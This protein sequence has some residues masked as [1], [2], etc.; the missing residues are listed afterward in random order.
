MYEDKKMILPLTTKMP[1]KRASLPRIVFTFSLGLSFGFTLS[2]L[3]LSPYSSRSG[4]SLGPFSKVA[5]VQQETSYVSPEFLFKSVQA[6]FEMDLDLNSTFVHELLRSA[7]EV[8]ARKLAQQVRILC[9]VITVPKNHKDRAEHVR[10]TW[11]RHCNNI[12]FISTKYDA[13]LP[14]TNVKIA[15]GKN[16]EWAK[17]EGA[18]N[19]L[20]ETRLKDFDWVVKTD[21]ESFIVVEN[22]RTMLTSYSPDDPIY[23][24]LS[25][26]VNDNT[27]GSNTASYVLSRESVIRLVIEGYN[28]SK[29]AD[30]SGKDIKTQLGS[31]FKALKL[32]QESTRDELNRR[33]CLPFHQAEDLKDIQNLEGDE[34]WKNDYVYWPMNAGLN[35]CSSEPISFHPTQVSALYMLEYMIYHVRPNSVMRHTNIKLPEE[36]I[37][38]SASTPAAKSS[39]TQS[40][41]KPTSE[42]TP[43]PTSSSPPSSTTTTTIKASSPPSSA[44]PAGSSPAPT[45]PKS[46]QGTATSATSTAAN[47][48]MT[49]SSAS[50]VA[51]VTSAT[52]SV[53]ATAKSK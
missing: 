12:H 44:G 27:T 6:K 30:C 11:G 29:H 38:D 23:F 14:T 13:A 28:G 2:T 20:H 33:R 49:G 8:A 21:H 40:T 25:Y 26:G 39:S 3:I 37:K 45:T 48:S 41:V 42:T 17:M 53:A 22:L 7:E 4:P 18:F 50:S 5:F 10:E 52:S 34:W 36:K 16:L 15:E 31:C 47:T 24:E 1:S 51:N 43:K 35:C 9:I 32:K 19:Y 46:D